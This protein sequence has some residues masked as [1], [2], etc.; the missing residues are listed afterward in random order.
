MSS[1]SDWADKKLTRQ[2]RGDMAF[3]YLDWLLTKNVPSGGFRLLYAITQCLN[4]DQFLHCSPSIEYLAARIG[5]A[6][7]TVWEMLRKLEEIGAV[8]IEWGSQGRGHT[9]KYRLHQI[10]A[11]TGAAP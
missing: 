2:E 9:N 10:P 6:P 1:N 7:S 5:R 3:R 11:R 4:E 8:E